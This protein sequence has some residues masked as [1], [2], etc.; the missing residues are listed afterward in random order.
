V[1]NSAVCSRPS[2]FAERDSPSFFYFYIY[3]FLRGSVVRRRVR[4]TPASSGKQTP[5]L[6][7]APEEL[8][9]GFISGVLSRAI[10]TPLSMITVRLQT[11]SNEEDPDSSE[12]VGVKDVIKSIYHEHGLVG[13]WRGASV[14]YHF[15]VI[16]PAYLWL[17]FETTVA[18]SLNP[19][20]TYSLI[21][22]FQRG[23][24]RLDRRRSSVSAGLHRQ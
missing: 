13:F 18:L 5:V 21:Q 7:S 14:A 23:L 8:G 19:A 16:L 6:L 4:L 20:L 22:L 10:S 9:L 11:Q 12:R 17:G 15:C 3:S 2:P 24:D 1:S